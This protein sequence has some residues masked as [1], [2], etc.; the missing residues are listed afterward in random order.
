MGLVAFADGEASQERKRL[1][2]CGINR[3]TYSS[4]R[5]RS[6]LAILLETS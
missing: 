1:E 2:V 6:W 3:I 5:L 4:S